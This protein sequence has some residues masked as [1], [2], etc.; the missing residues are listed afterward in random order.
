MKFGLKSKNA[1]RRISSLSS[2]S[3]LSHSIF[4][5]IWFFKEFPLFLAFLQRYGNE[6]L[7]VFSHN[8]EKNKNSMVKNVLIKR[9]K[10][11]RIFLHI[12]AMAV[13]AIGILVSPF[14]SDSGIFSQDSSLQT[15]AQESS[16]SSVLAPDD[17]FQ[18]QKSEKPRDHIVNYTVQKGDTLSTIAKNFGISEDTIRWENDLT[19]DSITVGDSLQILPVTGVSYKVQSGD[20]IYT[21]AKKFATN[22]QGIVDFP[23]N[24][25]ANPQTFSLVVGEILI[26]PN[27]VEPQQQTSRPTVPALPQYIGSAPGNVSGLGFTWP[28]H[29]TMNQYFSWYHQAVDLGDPIGTPIAAAQDGTVQTAIT[30]GWNTGYG[31]YVVIRGDNGYSTL[32]A[33]M[34]A[35]NVSAGQ[36]VQAGRTVLGWIGV[37]GNSTG[38]HLHFEIR[39][40]STDVH[41]NPLSFLP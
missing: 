10:R 4:G 18:T 39:S 13:L 29:G 31:N 40:S 1:A 19:G 22:P 2:E 41:Y 24:D 11:N 35:V 7:I 17:V 26:V 25:F 37:T 38:P 5:T 27:G 14:I 28:I 30:G 34:E 3:V 21:I 33:H 9:G 36:R 15:F 6:K 20:T 8:F 32:Y 16:S 12:S 23:F